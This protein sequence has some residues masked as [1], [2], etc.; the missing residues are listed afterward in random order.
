MCGVHAASTARLVVHCTGVELRVIG[1]LQS[2]VLGGKGSDLDD[3]T[4]IL[5]ERSSDDSE[6]GV[7]CVFAGQKKAADLA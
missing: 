2:P 7:K 1:S 6:D 5:R 4:Y 3:L